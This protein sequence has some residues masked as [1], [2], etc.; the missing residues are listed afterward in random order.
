MARYRFTA[1]RRRALAHA[2]RVKEEEEGRR[3]R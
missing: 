2:R 3:R 1:A